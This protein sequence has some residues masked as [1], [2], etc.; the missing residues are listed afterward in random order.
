MP[1]RGRMKHNQTDRHSG[2]GVMARPTGLRR[3]LV[4]LPARPAERAACPRA[5]SRKGKHAMGESKS[6]FAPGLIAPS[7]RAFL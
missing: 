3:A 5:P 1:S 4:D 2:A 6:S 7:K